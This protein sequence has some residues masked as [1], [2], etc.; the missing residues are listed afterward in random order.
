MKKRL[1]IGLFGGSF[2][3]VHKAHIKLAEAAKDE[4]RL[5]KIIF[6]P[7]RIPPHKKRKLAPAADRLKMIS[8]ALKNRACF[9][10]S[11]YELDKKS[12]SYTFRTVRHFRR[13]YPRADIFFI[14]GSDSLKELKTWKKPEEILA[15]C[16]LI[17][18]RRKGIKIKP[19]RNLNAKILF[20]RKTLPG[21]SATEARSAAAN[22]RK[23]E[24]LVPAQ[25]AC[26]IRKKGLYL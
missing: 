17:V 7:A 23:L 10:V 4:F 16:R 9:C 24:S 21:I 3:P 20:S 8:L 22:R 13:K 5:D 11:P 19:S 18:F 12:I 25:A 14:M 6:I 15:S 1:R 26:Y 2:D